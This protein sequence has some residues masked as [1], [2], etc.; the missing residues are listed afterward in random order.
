MLAHVP[1]AQTSFSGPKLGATWSRIRFGLRQG[2]LRVCWT[3]RR[4]LAISQLHAAHGVVSV[5]ICT[6]RCDDGLQH[7]VLSSNISGN[8]E[9]PLR[10]SSPPQLVRTQDLGISHGFL[11]S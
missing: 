4:R 5:L 3:E 2:C 6:P 1:H 7:R 8:H 11:Q 9:Y 10:K